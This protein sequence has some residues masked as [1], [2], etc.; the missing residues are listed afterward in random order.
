VDDLIGLVGAVDGL[1]QMQ[2][3]ADAE[4]FLAIFGRPLG[5]EQ[6]AAAAEAFLK[7][8]RYQYIV[9]G[10]QEER[11]EK[12]LGGMITP[13]HGQRV[14]KALE[15]IVGRLSSDAPSRRWVNGPAG[16][17]GEAW[18]H[19]RRFHCPFKRAKLPRP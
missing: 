8:Y 19:E 10:V 3:K 12:A 2:A 13:V 1:A 5:A 17:R 16:R 4:Y 6:R 9:S 7:A 11:F 14:G 18:T 15:G